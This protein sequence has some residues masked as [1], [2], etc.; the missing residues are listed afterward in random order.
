MQI[1]LAYVHL[2]S[3]CLSCNYCSKEIERTCTRAGIY[4]YIIRYLMKNGLKMKYCKRSS[5]SFLLYFNAGQIFFSY[6]KW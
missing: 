4:K 5:H 1:I 2:T 3:F 6:P